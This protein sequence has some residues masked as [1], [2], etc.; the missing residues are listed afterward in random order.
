MIEIRVK[1]REKEV[2]MQLSFI[3]NKETRETKKVN[4]KDD[5]R[6]KEILLS[7]SSLITCSAVCTTWCCYITVDFAT[8]SSKNGFTQYVQAF[9]SIRQPILFRKWQKSIRF[10]YFHLLPSSRRETR[11][12]YDTF[13]ELCKH[14]F[15]MQMLLNPTLCSSTIFIFIDNTVNGLRKVYFLIRHIQLRLHLTVHVLGRLP[16]LYVSGSMNI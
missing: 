3:P 2:C 16:I 1:L 14:R 7:E 6:E 4:E 15:V 13:V 10:F 12:V 8:A 9:S 5:S 11:S